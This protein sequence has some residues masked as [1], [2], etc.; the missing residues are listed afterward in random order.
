M[1]IHQ[2]VTVIVN[3]RFDSGTKIHLFREMLHS[4]NFFCNSALYQLPYSTW[5]GD[6]KCDL[7]CKKVDRT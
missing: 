4:Q 5:F 1:V 6:A 3:Q 7:E 2:L